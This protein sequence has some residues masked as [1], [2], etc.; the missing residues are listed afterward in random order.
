MGRSTNFHHPEMCA[1]CD[2]SGAPVYSGARRCTSGHHGAVQCPPTSSFGVLTP[3]YSWVLQGTTAKSSV[4]PNPI[5]KIF[6]PIPEHLMGMC[7]S[8]CRTLDTVDL[9]ADRYVF[10]F[11]FQKFFELRAPPFSTLRFSHNLQCLTP[12]VR[13]VSPDWSR[14]HSVLTASFLLETVKEGSEEER[15]EEHPV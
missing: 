15:T 8:L 9:L 2:R 13:A 6:R 14:Y 10:W 4:T 5:V 3:V 7:S 11:R 1:F 12:A